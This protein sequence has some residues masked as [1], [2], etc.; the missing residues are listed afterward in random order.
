MI[1]LKA[2]GSFVLLGPWTEPI[3][4]GR[5]FLSFLCCLVKDAIL[6][7]FLAGQSIIQVSSCNELIGPICKPSLDKGRFLL[8]SATKKRMTLCIDY[9]FLSNSNNMGKSLFKNP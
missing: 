7:R 8:T 1:T 3:T 5:G 2:L 4:R 6:L 9:L